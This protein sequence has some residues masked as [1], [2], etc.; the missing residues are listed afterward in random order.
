[1]IGHYILE[2]HEPVPCDDW[3]AWARWFE[4][5]ERIV[6]QTHLIDGSKVSTVFLGLDHSFGSGPPILFETCLFSGETEYSELLKRDLHP[7]EVVDRYATWG[8]AMD[9]HARWLEK[10]VL[11]EHIASTAK[12]MTERTEEP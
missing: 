7:S 8:E 9:G 3:M 1:M 5:A 2:G 11:P 6:A 12:H 4:K 10:C